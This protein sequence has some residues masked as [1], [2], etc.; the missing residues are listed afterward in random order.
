MNAY[1]VIFA[2]RICKGRDVIKI[3]KQS[4]PYFVSDDANDLIV[5]HALFLRLVNKPENKRGVI[6]GRSQVGQI[7]YPNVR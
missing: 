5:A 2:S 1:K 4:K 6:D 7:K 3:C